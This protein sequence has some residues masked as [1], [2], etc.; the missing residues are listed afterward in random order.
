MTRGHH[1]IFEFKHVG[2]YVK[3][4]AVCT[5]TGAEVSIVG[6]PAA[7]EQELQNVAKNKLMY[8]LKKRAAG[9]DRGGLLV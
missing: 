9:S 1:I 6:D 4:T 8:V 2:R 3:V 5:E 7:S